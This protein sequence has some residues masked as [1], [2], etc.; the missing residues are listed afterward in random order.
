MAERVTCPCCGYRTL[1][2]GPGAYEMCEVC[3]WGGRRGLTRADKVRRAARSEHALEPHLVEQRDSVDL[4][5]ER[6]SVRGGEHVLDYVG[7]PEA[8]ALVEA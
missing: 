7:H 3:G 4:K 6:V 2:D 1:P 5:P 8:T